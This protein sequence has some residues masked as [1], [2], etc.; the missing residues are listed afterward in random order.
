MKRQVNICS[1]HMESHVSSVNFVC[2]LIICMLFCSKEP[3]PSVV[4]TLFLLIVFYPIY[5]HPEAVSAN[6]MTSVS[7]ALPVGEWWA[8]LFHL[9]KC[10]GSFQPRWPPC[11]SC[12]R[13]VLCVHTSVCV[14]SGVIKRG[15]EVVR[16]T[17]E[18]SWIRNTLKMCSDIL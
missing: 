6:P 17:G 3:W 15:C 16:K 1:L 5:H 2:G 13:V 7:A 8:R 9:W 4:K 18:I 12:L 11:W 14:G 10:W